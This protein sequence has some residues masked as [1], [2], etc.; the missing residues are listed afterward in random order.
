MNSFWALC[1]LDL[2]TCTRTSSDS[3]RPWG[4]LADPNP[5]W[6]YD[7]LGAYCAVPSSRPTSP[8]CPVCQ[9]FVECWRLLS[10]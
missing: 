3:V 9:N 10:H 4:S 1:V 2:S 7:W 8:Y 6:M 5:Q